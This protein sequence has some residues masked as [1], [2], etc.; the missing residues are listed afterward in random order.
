MFMFAKW[1][2]RFAAADAFSCTAHHRKMYSNERAT[3]ACFA[4]EKYVR[5]TY[6][7]SPNVTS[8]CPGAMLQ[9]PR[10]HSFWNTAENIC[11]QQETVERA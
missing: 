3:N 4:R 9:T 8:P 7:L 11:A 10:A 5:R 6:L 1:R 2:S